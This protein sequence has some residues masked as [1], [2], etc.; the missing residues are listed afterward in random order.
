MIREILIK[1]LFRLIGHG[2]ASAYKDIN[3]ELVS[4]WAAKQYSEPGFEEYFRLRDLTLLKTIAMGIEGKDYWTRV[5]QRLELIMLLDRASEAHK[6]NVK[7]LEA[8]KRQAEQ[9]QRSDSKNNQATT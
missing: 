3:D 8:Q 6:A 9:D 1:I 5:G 4:S 2:D 7:R